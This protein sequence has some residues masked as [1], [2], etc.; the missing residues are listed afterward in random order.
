MARAT[1]PTPLRRYLDS[2]EC[3]QDVF[4]DAWSEF[5]SELDKLVAMGY[6]PYTLTW[7]SKLRKLTLKQVLYSDHGRNVIF[8]S[9]HAKSTIRELS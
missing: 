6:D 8:V 2:I 1:P 3:L 5:A 7:S 4:G 9:K